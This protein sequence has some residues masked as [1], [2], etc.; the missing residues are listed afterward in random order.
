MK[1]KIE[2][3]IDLGES[4]CDALCPE[5]VQ[6]A[7]RCVEET[8]TIFLADGDGCNMDYFPIEITYCGSFYD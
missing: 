5:E 1:V 6:W 8:N 7:R 3:I 2:A 4:F